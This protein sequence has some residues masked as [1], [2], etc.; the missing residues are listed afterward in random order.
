MIR[1]FALDQRAYICPSLSWF[2]RHGSQGGLQP[3]CKSRGILVG[4]LIKFFLGVGRPL[5]QN[6]VSGP[7]PSAMAENF[8]SRIDIY[9]Q[10]SAPTI[11]PL[12]IIHS[13]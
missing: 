13:R 6:K 7:G 3:A 1:L 10:P 12:A 8:F 11:P 5:E 4:E 9:S 2:V